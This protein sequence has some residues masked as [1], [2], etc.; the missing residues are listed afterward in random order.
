M[1]N[2]YNQ[3]WCSTKNGDGLLLAKSEDGHVKAGDED[4]KGPTN[5][6]DDPQM[7]QLH[8]RTDQKSV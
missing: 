6:N 5:W 4:Q 1:Y 7:A 3:I 2:V 8:K